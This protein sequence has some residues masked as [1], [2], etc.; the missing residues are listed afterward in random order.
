MTSAAFEPG[1]PAIKPLQTYA[2]GRMATGIGKV[3]HAHARTHAHAH[4]CRY[5][6]MQR[7]DRIRIFFSF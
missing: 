1:I 2:L 4:T 5:Q 6:N 3:T 7:H